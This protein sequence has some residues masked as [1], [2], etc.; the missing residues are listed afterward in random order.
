MYIPVDPTPTIPEHSAPT[1]P[2]ILPPLL[3]KSIDILSYFNKI[4]N[5][6]L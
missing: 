1:I 3:M 6:K 4:L 5:I 2:V